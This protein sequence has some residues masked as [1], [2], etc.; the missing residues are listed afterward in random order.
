[1]D[2]ALLFIIVLQFAYI[3]YK[4]VSFSKERDK[5]SI[6]SLSKNVDEY[7][8]AVKSIEPV[9][10]EPKKEEDIYI[11]VEDLSVD[12]VLKAKDNT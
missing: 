11:S 1:M 2:L 8:S 9:E 6:K 12:E 4:D 3:V 10:E 5:L 7:V